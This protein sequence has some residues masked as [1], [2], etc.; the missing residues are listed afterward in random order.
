MVSKQE[1]QQLVTQINDIL[2]R[3]DKRLTELEESAKTPKTTANPRSKTTS[4]Q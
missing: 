2:T 1:L 4:K 3:L